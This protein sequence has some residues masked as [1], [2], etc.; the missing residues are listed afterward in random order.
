MDILTILVQWGP[1][2]QGLTELMND[3]SWQVLRN[4]YALG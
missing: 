2:L 1:Y 4:R 3:P